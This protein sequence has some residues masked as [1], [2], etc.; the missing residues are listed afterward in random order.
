MLLV[1]SILIVNNPFAVA[2]D[3]D[4]TTEPAP[5]KSDGLALDALFAEQHIA[6][7]GVLIRDRAR[8]MSRQRAFKFLTDWVLPNDQHS[9]FRVTTDYV[10]S[11]PQSSARIVSPAIQWI[12][13]ANELKKIDEIRT[14]ISQSR[15][16]S[17]RDQCDQ[18]A[19]L[20]LLAIEEGSITLAGELLEQFFSLAL[21]DANLLH[22]T[23]QAILLCADQAAQSPELSLIVR[24]SAEIVTQH[25]LKEVHRT[26]WHRHFWATHATLH[27]QSQRHVN[28]LHS[29]GLYAD[30][31]DTTQWHRVSRSSAFEN[32]NGFPSAK[33]Y[34][35]AG[36]ARKMSTHGDDF[37]FFASPL[38]GSFDIETDVTG[39]GYR[40]TQ[41]MIAGEWTGL[42]YDHRHYAIGNISGELR[43]VPLDLPMQDVHSHGSIHIRTAVRETEATTFYNARPIHVQPLTP[44]RDPWIAVRSSHNTRGGVDDLRITGTPTIPDTIALVTSADLSEW[45][46]YFDTRTAA[47]HRLNDW[48]GTV[49]T[50]PSGDTAT[51]ITDARATELPLGSSAERLL[52]YSRPMIENGS[53]EYEFWYTPGETIAHPAVG[54][55]CY[56][57]SDEG[58]RLHQLTDGRYERSAL[59][60]DNAS[61]ILGDQPTLNLLADAWNKMQV[62]VTGDELRL[63]LNGQLI[64][65][66][67]LELDRLERKFGLFHYADQSDLRVR[68]PHWTGNWP[69][70]MPALDEQDLAVY[71][72]AE[73]DR[74]A[75][76]LPEV[77]VQKIDEQSIL[78]RK[79]TVVSGNASA[80][81][82]LSDDGVRLSRDGNEGYSGTL[83][84][85]VV[86]VGGDFDV[87]LSYDQLEYKAT[88]G[89]VAS[90]QMYVRAA[91]EYT[92]VGA[93]QCTKGRDDK[94]SVQ[95]LKMQ[96]VNGEDRRHYFG[97][98]PTEAT[99]GRIRICRR[100]NKIYYLH[101][102]ND[103]TQ[104][105]LIGE[106]DFTVEDLQDLGI[107]FGVQV[108]G[109]D[110][111]SRARFKKIEIR[112]ERLGGLVT[113]SADAMLAKFNGQREQLPV[114]FHCDF[115]TTPLDTND[116]HTWGSLSDWDRST[117]GILVDA[118][119]SDKWTS[120]G[121]SLKH[122]IHG[123]FDITFAFQANQLAVPKEGD[124]TQ[125]FLQVE[126]SD[127]D[128]MQ[129]NA[130]LS[131]SPRDA[132]VSQGQFRTRNG[133][134]YSYNR[135]G[136]LGITSPDYL[137]LLRR[138]T[139][140]YIYAGVESEKH[141]YLIGSTSAPGVPLA[142]FGVRMMLHTGGSDRT[143]QMLVKSLDVKAQ[144]L[145]RL[146]VGQIANP[147]TRTITPRTPKPSTP[148]TK[149]L[150]TRIIE[151]VR[152][153]FQ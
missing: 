151:S 107:Q 81:V 122:V 6:E 5:R 43:R 146:E 32:G 121:I 61:E 60:S 104:F 88:P 34:I 78:D 130:M 22:E 142:P 152:G 39:F 8:S 112:A 37:L 131:K 77:F 99:A 65:Q 70:Q 3:A 106:E 9:G 139:K 109:T 75:E 92:D 119:G 116:F 53:I 100:A 141:E 40:D 115:S 73:L 52:V 35:T 33:W 16:H 80:D 63:L 95:C 50:H 108:Q 89:K 143:S 13:L 123:D 94:F 125:V 93:V 85:T 69:K 101:A 19:L 126:T 36:S 84:G 91:N 102:E 86:D 83:L 129:F 46:D 26:A 21:S 64:H 66:T 124:Y 127:V 76:D 68:N 44:H 153:L 48:K 110:G 137:R 132:I 17:Q 57:L 136:S 140:I 117:G 18:S 25:Y 111:Y 58:V 24:D 1:G 55:R 28:T 15:I 96:T 30:E 105:Q 144:Q 82:R 103:S 10:A 120:A 133:E 29:S 97:R 45:Y 41:L 148:P 149:S 114:S 59:R 14:A 31:L 79:F 67:V 20:A 71:A 51:E 56:L 74:T 87:V 23:R 118:V 135:M 113:E 49:E 11:S 90:I 147:G 42:I 38:Q 62:E 134:R 128:R 72:T 138:D 150:P 2:Q 98:H 4:L 7:S 27:V 47:S 12:R 54:R 145:T